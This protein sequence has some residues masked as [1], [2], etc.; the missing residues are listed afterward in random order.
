MPIL[1]G[2]HFDAF[3]PKSSYKRRAADAPS[4]PP[5]VLTISPATALATEIGGLVT[6]TLKAWD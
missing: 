5:P 3:R 4:A 6:R 1:A 2:A